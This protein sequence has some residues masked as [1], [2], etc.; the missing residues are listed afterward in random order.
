M[1]TKY[2]Y[3][4][5]KIISNTAVLLIFWGIIYLMFSFLFWSVY[6]RDWT[7]SGVAVFIGLLAVCVQYYIDKIRQII[8]VFKYGKT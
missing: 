3:I 6:M 2:K 8:R 1:T 5:F 7:Y 4:T